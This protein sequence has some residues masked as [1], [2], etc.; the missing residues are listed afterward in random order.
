MGGLLEIRSVFSHMISRSG[1]QKGSPSTTRALQ[2]GQLM[3]TERRRRK[4]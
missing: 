4:R 3:A 1:Q 2:N